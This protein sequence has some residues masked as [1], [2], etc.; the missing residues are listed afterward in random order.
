MLGRKRRWTAAIAA[1]AALAFVAIG[2]PAGA[3][4]FING[5][6]IKPGSIGEH[7]DRERRDRL[8]EAVEEPAPSR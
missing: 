6:S 5:S 7:A 1:V 2:G 3:K 4:H 8:D